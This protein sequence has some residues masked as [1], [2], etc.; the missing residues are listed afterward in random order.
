MVLKG[1]CMCIIRGRCREEG[2]GL[3]VSVAVSGSS[4]APV[5]T[6]G[7]TGLSGGD[8]VGVG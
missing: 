5:S 2:Q 1:S 7:V 8:M 6:R 3:K 4:L